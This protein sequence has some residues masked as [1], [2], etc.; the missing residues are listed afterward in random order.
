MDWEIELVHLFVS[1]GHNFNG[2]HGKGA[3]NHEIDDR[4]VID[5]VAGR[6]IRGDRYYDH[7]ENYKGQVTFFDH[8]V[9]EEVKDK[10]ELPHLAASAFRR[11]VLVR[12]VPLTELIGRSFSIQGVEFEGVEEAAPCYW[13]DKACAKGV[14][15]FLIGRGGLRARIVA[16]GE[17]KRGAGTVTRLP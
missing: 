17:L 4:D 9:Y 7:K 15:E 5:C 14:H 16:G 2:R 1:E 12:G 10:F 6:G 11:N 8:D 13:M 3:L